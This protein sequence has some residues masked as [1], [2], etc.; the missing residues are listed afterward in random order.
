MM[1]LVTHFAS[2]LNPVGPRDDQGTAG[3]TGILG[4]AFEHLERRREP[5][6]PS[7]RI[8]VIGLSASE[9]VE[10][11]YVL[12]HLVGEVVEEFVFVYRA[13]RAAFTRSSVVSAIE[14][15]RV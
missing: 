8:V 12:R 4:V 13:V 6:R 14:N 1:V 5:N 7:S 2:R 15:K 10:I 3:A 11:L 9:N